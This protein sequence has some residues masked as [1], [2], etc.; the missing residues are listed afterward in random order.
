M[1]HFSRLTSVKDNQIDMGNKGLMFNIITPLQKFSKGGT[2]ITDVIKQRFH[3]LFQRDITN[4]AREQVE[5]V[6]TKK[7]EVSLNTRLYVRLTFTEKSSD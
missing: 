5:N 2:T 4:E 6:F 3:D 7:K 1:S